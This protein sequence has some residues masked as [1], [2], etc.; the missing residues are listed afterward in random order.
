MSYL[1]CA[2]YDC[3]HNKAGCCCLD[4]INYVTSPK[5]LARAFRRVHTFLMPGGLFLFDIN[6]PQKLRG[7]DGQM[8]LDESEDAYCVWRAD[9]SERRRI[10]TYGMDIFRLEPGGLWSRWEEVHEEYAYEPAELEELLRQAGFRQIR[11]YGEL[12]FRAPREGSSGF[13]LPHERNFDKHGRQDHSRFGQ[14]RASEGIG[15]HG[16]RRWWS[17]PGRFTRLCPWPPRPWA[18]A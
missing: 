16:Q 6:T 7:L 8:F 14:G 15:D 18:A 13:S 2:Q 17:A 4:S 3:C 9:W 12:R 5:K 1:D 11:Q 10:C